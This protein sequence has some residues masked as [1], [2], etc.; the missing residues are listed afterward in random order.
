[1][2]RVTP[3][4]V[5][6]LPIGVPKVNDAGLPQAQYGRVAVQ[7][8]VDQVALRY[9]ADAPGAIAAHNRQTNFFFP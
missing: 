4:D 8:V 3:G 2:K 9:D 1:M 6:F 7:R 5:E